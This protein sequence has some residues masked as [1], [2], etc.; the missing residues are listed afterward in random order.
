MLTNTLDNPSVDKGRGWRVPDL[1]LESAG[2]LDDFDGKIAI[3]VEDGGRIVLFTAGI[4]HCERT[5]S[6]QVEE[7]GIFFGFR[8]KSK[9]L[10]FT[11]GQNLQRPMRADFCIYG[12]AGVRNPVHSLSLPA[13]SQSVPT[14]YRHAK[15]FEPVGPGSKAGL[16]H[17][18]RQSKWTLIA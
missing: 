13:R 11:L 3:T 5:T 7:P 18:L 10:H 4:Q 8:G 12:K 16:A 9:L 17:I 15:M 6:K 2:A 14:K 1:E